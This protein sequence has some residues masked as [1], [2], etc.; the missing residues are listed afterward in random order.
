MSA[1]KPLLSVVEAILKEHQQLL[2]LATRKKQVLI[3]GDMEALHLIVQEENQFVHRIERLEQE[4]IG[5]GRLLAVRFG[6]PVTEL[7]ASKV[8][9][10]A[11]SPEEAQRIQ[12][13][14][15]TLRAVVA[16]LKQLNDLNTQLIQQS[17]QFVRTSIEVLTEAPEVPTYGGNGQMNNPYVV[18]KTSY[19]DSKA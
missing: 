12:E 7:T 14:T 11:E 10:M 1:L 16:E 17:L 6:V 19:F 15:D 2:E 5:A 3:K 18:A 13:L 8:V 4:R 9:T